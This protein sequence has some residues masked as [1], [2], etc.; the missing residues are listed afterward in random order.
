MQFSTP[1]GS[2]ALIRS[3]NAATDQRSGI[4]FEADSSINFTSGG[5]VNRMIIDNTGFVGIRTSAPASYLDVAASTAYAISTSTVS[6]TLDEFD[7]THIILPTASSIL[8]TLPAANTCSR[9]E[10][11]IVNEDN[12]LQLISSYIDFTGAA[13]ITLLANT[14]ITIQSNGINWYRIR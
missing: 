12:S 11:T 5:S 2:P 10:Y 9:R 7:H 8:I 1:N 3:G 13:N 14:S 4:T 6:T